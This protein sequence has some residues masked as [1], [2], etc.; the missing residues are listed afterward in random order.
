MSRFNWC[1]SSSLQVTAESNAPTA[2]DKSRFSIYARCMS[3]LIPF[4][5]V[6]ILKT[7]PFIENAKEPTS[8][9]DHLNSGLFTTTKFKNRHILKIKLYFDDCVSVIPGRFAATSTSPLIDASL[10]IGDAQLLARAVHLYEEYIGQEWYE[11]WDSF[12][13]VAG[14]L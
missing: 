13:W 8:S 4:L 6:N 10:I 9:S 11:P 2:L 14:E 12:A 5:F 3:D 7:S 1:N